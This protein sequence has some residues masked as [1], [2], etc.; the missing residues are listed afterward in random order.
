MPILQSSQARLKKICTHKSVN[1]KKCSLKLVAFRTPCRAQSPVHCTVQHM[2]NGDIK[3]EAKGCLF[4]CFISTSRP[5]STLPPEDLRLQELIP[6]LNPW[7]MPLRPST[8]L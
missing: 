3:K 1:N 4:P 2:H 6:L 8:S 7:P 5:C